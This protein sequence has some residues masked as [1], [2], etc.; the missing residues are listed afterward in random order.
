MQRLCDRIYFLVGSIAELS[1]QLGIACRV[2]VQTLCLEAGNKILLFVS[3][4]FPN[5]LRILSYQ[6]AVSVIFLPRFHAFTTSL[7]SIILFRNN[8][9][10]Y[11]RYNSKSEL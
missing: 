4:F 10:K 8:I 6:V 11:T 3:L 9:M 2:D 1:L 5:P 7:T